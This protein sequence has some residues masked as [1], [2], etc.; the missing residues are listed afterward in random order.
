MQAAASRAAVGC[1]S[2]ASF[3]PAANTSWHLL[4]RQLCGRRLASRPAAHRPAAR[5]IDCLIA[6]RALEHARDPRASARL[7][8]LPR[9]KCDASPAPRPLATGRR[10]QRPAVGLFYPTLTA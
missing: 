3:S 1:W 10:G 8:R 4:F 7:G 9:A 6:S 2:M 5:C